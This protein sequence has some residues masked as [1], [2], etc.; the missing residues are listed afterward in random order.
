MSIYNK[1]NNREKG[2]TVFIIGS[3]PQHIF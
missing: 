2:K 1:L 3:G